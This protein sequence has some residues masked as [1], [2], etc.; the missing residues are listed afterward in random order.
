MENIVE[1]LDPLVR[2]FKK[3][4]LDQEYD[5]GDRDP[6]PFFKFKEF[7]QKK[8][9]YFFL[10]EK[11]EE[12]KYKDLWL[13]SGQHA[14]LMKDY[15]KGNIFDLFSIGKQIKY[16]RIEDSAKSLVLKFSIFRDQDHVLT[17]KSKK[18]RQHLKDLIRNYF[19]QHLKG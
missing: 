12:G 13:F 15:Q 5:V 3:E 9:E 1:Q 19:L 10:P 4:F 7:T 16:L 2:K 18:N 6:E 8:P 17:A 14:M 11:F